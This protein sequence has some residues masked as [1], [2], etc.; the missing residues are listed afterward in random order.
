[1]SPNSKEDYGAIDS[2]KNEQE[3]RWLISFKACESVN[4]SWKNK[5]A[6]NFYDNLCLLD[7]RM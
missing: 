2:N 5:A 1:M 4:A 6:L 3:D 7:M